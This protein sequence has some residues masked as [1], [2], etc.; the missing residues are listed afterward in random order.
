MPNDLFEDKSVNGNLIHSLPN[1]P[2]Y[3]GVTEATPESDEY[4]DQDWLFRDGIIQL[5]NRLDIDKLYA[6]SHNS[7]AI[8][9]IW[10]EHHRKFSKFVRKHACSGGV[11]ELGGGHGKL[12]ALLSDKEDLYKD[13]TVIEPGENIENEMDVNLIKSIFDETTR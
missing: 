10:E 12:H 7:G 3:V 11:L 6:H 13:W 2:V 8:G 9:K 1:Q 5:K 4:F